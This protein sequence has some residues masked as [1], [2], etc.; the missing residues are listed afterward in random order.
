MN[1][2][3][4]STNRS[5]DHHFFLSLKKRKHVEVVDEEYNPLKVLKAVGEIGKGFV[6]SVYFLKPPRLRD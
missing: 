6:R 5:S 3:Q 4:I 2:L 1:S